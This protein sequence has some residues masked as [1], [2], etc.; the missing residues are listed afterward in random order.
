MEELEECQTLD[1]ISM[2]SNKADGGKERERER[3]R[4]K[5]VEE[6]GERG[7]RDNQHELRW[8]ERKRVEEREKRHI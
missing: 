8:H 4:E 6:T 5:G 7:E 1:W 3:E 2:N